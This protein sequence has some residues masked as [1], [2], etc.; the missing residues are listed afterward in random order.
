MLL[1]AGVHTADDQATVAPI[2]QLDQEASVRCATSNPGLHIPST[3]VESV[4]TQR[5]LCDRTQ[6]IVPQ[7]SHGPWARRLDGHPG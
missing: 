5:G 3:N 2:E 4:E 6:T 1:E 7:V